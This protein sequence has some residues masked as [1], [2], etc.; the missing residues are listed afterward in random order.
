M[1]IRNIDFCFSWCAHV[2]IHVY[3]HILSRLSLC[4]CVC[5]TYM[6]I[7]T[8]LSLCVCVCVHVSMYIRACLSL[9]ACVCTW[10]SEGSIG[11]HPSL[12]ADGI[13]HLPGAQVLMKIKCPLASKLSILD[14]FL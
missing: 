12:F 7:H 6:Y 11:Y 5:N 10:R 3:I 9:C 13:S 4:V 2:C 14:F 1:I 8:C